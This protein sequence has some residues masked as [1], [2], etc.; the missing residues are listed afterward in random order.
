MTVRYVEGVVEPFEELARVLRSADWATNR[1]DGD[2]QR[3]L[4]N[5]AVVVSTWDDKRCL[6]IVRIIDDGVYRALIEDVV[7]DPDARGHG[8]GRGLVELA[9]SRPGVVDVEELI[10]FTM[11]PD[12]WSCFGFEQAGGAMKRF[13]TRTAR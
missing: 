3:A 8:I 4:A 6:R 7:V 13:R 12:F 5:S 10:L 9:L 2:I 1:A 11:V